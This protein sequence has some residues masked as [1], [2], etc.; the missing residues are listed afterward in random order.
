MACEVEVRPGDDFKSEGGAMISMSNNINLSTHVEG[1]C[2]TACCRCC[3]AGEV[4]FPF[5]TLL[6]TLGHAGWQKWWTSRL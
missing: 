4:R 1:S 3:C 2:F 5:V 6:T